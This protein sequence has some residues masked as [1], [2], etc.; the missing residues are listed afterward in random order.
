MELRGKGF[1]PEFFYFW[2]MNYL[3]KE[4]INHFISE[5]LREDIGDGDR[6]KNNSPYNKHIIKQIIQP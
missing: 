3:S 1:S 5:A 4:A 2:P 6:S